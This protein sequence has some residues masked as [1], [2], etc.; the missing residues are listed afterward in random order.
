MVTYTHAHGQKF[1]CLK[2]CVLLLVSRRALLIGQ[3]IGRTVSG[4]DVEEEKY[5]LEGSL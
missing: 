5:I 4:V 1:Q 3:R 2:N